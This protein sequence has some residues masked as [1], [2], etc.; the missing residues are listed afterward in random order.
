MSTPRST[1]RTLRALAAV[2][3]LSLLLF[4]CSS[5][6]TTETA[7]DQPADATEAAAATSE[8]ASA[9]TT[10]DA[11]ASESAGAS[12]SDAS[13]SAGG[14]GEL[15]ADR[16]EPTD[17]TPDEE[18]RIAMIGFA[19]NPYWVVVES[20][21]QEANKVL[22]E[23]NGSVDWIVAGASIDVATVNAAVRAAAAQGYDGIG[24]FIAGEGNCQTIED[25]TADG[26][27]LGVYNTQLECVEESG[28]IIDYAQAQFE[29]GQTAAENMIEM[30]GGEGSVGI[31]TSQFT[32]P[33][34]EE[35]RMGFID[36]LEGSDLT[37]VNEGVEAQDSAS[38]TFSAAQSFIQSNDDLVGIYATAGGPFGAAEAV[39]EAGKSEDITVIGYD[40]TPE[41]LEVLRNGSM[42]GLIGQ[43]AFGQ[44]YNVAIEL[45]NAAVTGEGPDEVLQDAFS[46]FVTLDNLDEYDP[47]Q[48]PVGTLGTS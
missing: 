23:R 18:V 7:D 36:G 4:A 37:P 11:A 38:D 12:E 33:G 20:G 39:E 44:G 42:D 2:A 28:G 3:L 43:D 10:E 35:R 45:Y 27:A 8:G 5:G 47:E 26:T 17:Q 16:P 22:A 21:A 24:F 25:L 19:N 31:V 6:D 14:G 29:A 30:T 46:P 34:A 48:N 40:I 1:R 15:I 13:E 32:A 9:A 41:N